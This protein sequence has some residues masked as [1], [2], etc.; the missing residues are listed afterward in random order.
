LICAVFPRNKKGDPMTEYK[1]GL[2]SLFSMAAREASVRYVIHRDFS[3]NKWNVFKK[4]GLGEEF[5]DWFDE[6]GDAQDF[7]DMNNGV[8]A[9]TGGER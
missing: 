1:V 5:I 7:C 6:L 9:A 3:E 8:V 4:V 2:G